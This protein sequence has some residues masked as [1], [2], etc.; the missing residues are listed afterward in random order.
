MK[1]PH[2][3]HFT[4]GDRFIAF[5]IWGVV[6]FLAGLMAL[7]PVTPAGFAAVLGIG[8]ACGI[9]GAIWPRAITSIVRALWNS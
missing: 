9:I 3:D 6:G 5:A 4:L 8:T 7:P 1:N 2:L